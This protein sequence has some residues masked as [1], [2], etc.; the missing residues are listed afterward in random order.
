VGVRNKAA[1]DV[2]GDS[3][4]ALSAALKLKSPGRPMSRVARELAFDAACGFYTVEVGTHVRSLRNQLPDDLSRGV[5]PPALVNEKRDLVPGRATGFWRTLGKAPDRET[6][7][8]PVLRPP[9]LSLRTAEQA[10][11]VRRREEVVPSAQEVGWSAR[12]ALWPAKEV[13]GQPAEG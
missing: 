9:N 5:V 12:V 7:A 13:S 1:V 3:T 8:A 6:G 4:A 10:E 11:E 2:L